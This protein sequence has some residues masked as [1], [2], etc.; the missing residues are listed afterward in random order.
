MKNFL[1]EPDIKTEPMSPSKPVH[2]VAPKPEDYYESD[3]SFMESESDSYEESDSYDSSSETSSDME[4]ESENSRWIESDSDR[5]IGPCF[6][7]CDSD[8]D[9][10]PPCL[11]NRPYIKAE[12]LCR[13]CGERFPNQLRR[14]F[15]EIG[16][17]RTCDCGQFHYSSFE[18]LH[19]IHLPECIKMPVFRCEWREYGCKA[20]FR[21]IRDRFHHSAVCLFEMNAP[22]ERQIHNMPNK[23]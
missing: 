21:K 20:E 11:L 3:S 6:D 14:N 22:K 9:L 15:H 13:H 5:P 18:E 23:F 10:P 8:A 7:G 19:N 16:H 2:F 12:N 17:L 4:T 1:P